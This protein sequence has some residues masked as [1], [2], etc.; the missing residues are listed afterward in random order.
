M[1]LLSLAAI[2]VASAAAP[3]FAEDLQFTLVNASSHDI[4]E[5]YLSPHDQNTWGDNILTVDAV[6]AGTQGEIS[7]ADGETV[8]DYDIKV[9]TAEGTSGEVTQNLCDLKTFTVHD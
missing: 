4:T 1:R 9:V 3:A 7:V 8:C 6:A 5:M 2:L